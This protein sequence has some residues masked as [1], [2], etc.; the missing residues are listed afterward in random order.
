M[1]TKLIERHS[2]S[3]LIFNWD[4]IHRTKDLIIVQCAVQWHFVH[5]RCLPPPP[6]S[7]PKSFHPPQ[8]KPGDSQAVMSSSPSSPQSL[9]TTDLSS[10]LW[11]HPL[12]D[13]SHTRNHT[14]RDFLYLYLLLST[15]SSRF[16]NV[17]GTGTH[18]SLCLSAM[19]SS[20]HM[21]IR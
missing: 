7:S 14:I 1:F 11:T 21:V 9:K 17:T 3:L 5:S 10:S 13:I 4:Q 2:I 6:L 15:V 20:V 8:R 12:M 16:T 19:P 18:P